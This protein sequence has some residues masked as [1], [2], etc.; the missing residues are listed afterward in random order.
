MSPYDTVQQKGELRIVIMLALNK[1]I[2][3]R[4]YLSVQFICLF[5]F[6]SLCVAADRNSTVTPEAIVHKFCELDAKGT[7]LS[8]ETFNN[9]ADLITWPEEGGDEMIIINGFTVGK[10]T[11]KDNKA[12]VPVHYNNLGSTDFFD[13]SPP[14]RSWANPYVYKLILKNGHWKIDEPVSAPHVDWKTAIT[15]IKN[16]Q[17]AEPDRKAY[18]NKIVQK[19]HKARKQIETE[20]K[21]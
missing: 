11:Y 5:L 14:K 8:S 18:L 1:M 2:N 7:R 20:K 10:A 4:H 13:F 21:S 3:R 9:I 17:K 6:V 15:Y 12:I 16:L 19:I